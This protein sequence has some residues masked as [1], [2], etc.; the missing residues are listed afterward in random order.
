M[1]FE[2]GDEGNVKA[3][4][5]EATSK[6]I[7]GEKTENGYIRRT[8]EEMYEFDSIIKARRLQWLGHMERVTEDRRIT[9]KTPG[10]KKKRKTEKKMEKG[11]VGEPE[12]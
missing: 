6:D 2:P 9:W 4:G 5:K 3:M 7:R 12:G 1:G 8:N 11:C 10:Y